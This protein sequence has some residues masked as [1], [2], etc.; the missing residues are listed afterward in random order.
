M[1]DFRDD[2]RDPRD[3]QNDERPRRGNFRRDEDDYEEDVY[4]RRG[5]TSRNGRGGGGDRSTYLVQAIL[6]TLF[7]CMPLGVVAIVYAAMASGK[8]SSG[9]YRGGRQNAESA[10]QWCWASLLLGIGV[11][12]IYVAAIIFAG[13]DPDNR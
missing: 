9:D 12:L 3:D 8:F 1:P 5:Y 11:V 10:K 7:C 6:C 4:S 2:D 13:V